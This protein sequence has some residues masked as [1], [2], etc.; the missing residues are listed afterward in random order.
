MR[1]HGNTYRFSQEPMYVSPFGVK[2]YCP[3]QKHAHSRSVLENA[4]M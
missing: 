2:H 3:A 1:A 4:R